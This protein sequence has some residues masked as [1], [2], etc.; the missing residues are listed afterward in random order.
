MTAAD[1]LF[2]P[3]RYDWGTSSRKAAT[4]RVAA[5]PFRASALAALPQAS[6]TIRPRRGIEVLVHARVPMQNCGSAAARRQ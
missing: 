1:A 4:D 3:G 6:P 2:R 5:L